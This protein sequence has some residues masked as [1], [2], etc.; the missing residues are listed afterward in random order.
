MKLEKVARE[1]HLGS[2]WSGM[3]KNLVLGA[4]QVDFSS[5]DESLQGIDNFDRTAAEESGYPIRFISES[6]ATPTRFQPWYERRCYS[7]LKQ[8]T[9]TEFKEHKKRLV[10]L[11]YGFVVDVQTDL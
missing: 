3:K 11:P 7:E 9:R 2:I 1:N 10:Q 5:C 6:S 4:R 8:A